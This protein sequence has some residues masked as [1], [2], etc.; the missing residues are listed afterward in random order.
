MFECE[1]IPST[2]VIEGQV[3]AGIVIS[4]IL[5]KKRVISLVSKINV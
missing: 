1:V 3:I 4:K 5:Q 2:N